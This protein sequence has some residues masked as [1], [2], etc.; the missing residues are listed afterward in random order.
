MIS[1]M[2]SYT[3]TAVE[4][5][6]KKPEKTTKRKKIGPLHRYFTTNTTFTTQET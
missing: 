6:S 1:M 5:I 3:N 2:G 4:K